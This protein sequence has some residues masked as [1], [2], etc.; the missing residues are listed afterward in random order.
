MAELLRGKTG[1]VFG[2]LTALLTLLKGTP[3]AYNRDFQED[4]PPAFD[5]VDTVEACLDVTI[6]MVRTLKVNREKMLDACRL[7]FLLATDVA[8][9][10]A[11]RGIPFREAHGLVAKA[12][13]Y[14]IEREISLEESRSP[15][16]GT[17]PPC[18]ALGF[19]KRS[20][21]TKPSP[22]VGPGAGPPPRKSN[23]KPN[24][25]ADEW[26]WGG[27]TT[28]CRCVVFGG[29]GQGPRPRTGF[30]V[31]TKRPNRTSKQ[32]AASLG[33]GGRADCATTHCRSPIS[34]LSEPGAQHERVPLSRH[35][36]RGS[37]GGIRINGF[38]S[39]G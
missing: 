25:F 12:V 19:W 33:S 24:R 1:R 21:W 6:P 7:G 26:G 23:V 38:V 20:R 15:S 18:R 3:L 31:G 14:A 27:E 13:H 36:L 10:F 34:L 8:D 29:P 9:A 37:A 32:S 28:H 17:F 22:P 39:V 35:R 2:D 30:D 11:R 5:A 4:K 16:G